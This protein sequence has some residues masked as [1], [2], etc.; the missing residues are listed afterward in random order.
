MDSIGVSGAALQVYKL[1]SSCNHRE[2]QTAFYKARQ[3]HGPYRLCSS[4]MLCMAILAVLRN[5][6]SVGWKACQIWLSLSA[7]ALLQRTPC[8][9]CN[10]PALRHQTAKVIFFVCPCISCDSVVFRHGVDL[11]GI[12]FWKSPC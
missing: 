4:W 9:N 6:Q 2:N 8:H 7:L 5:G 1:F 11:S 3:T 12:H 10:R